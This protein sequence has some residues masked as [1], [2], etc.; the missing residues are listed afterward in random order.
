M[1]RC[2]RILKISRGDPKFCYDRV[3][4]DGV[5]SYE[6]SLSEIHFSSDRR[7]GQRLDVHY[8]SRWGD[9]VF[10]DLWKGVK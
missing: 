4:R 9:K 5:A 8:V 1:N 6:P 2:G 10:Y 3:V 7:V